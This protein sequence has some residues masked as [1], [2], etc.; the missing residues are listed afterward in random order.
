MTNNWTQLSKNKK[1]RE[2]ITKFAI[3]YQR[4]VALFSPS[5]VIWSIYLLFMINFGAKTLKTKKPFDVWFEKFCPGA[6]LDEING[7]TLM[8][9][10]NISL[11]PS[12]YEVNHKGF[13]FNP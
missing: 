7:N 9:S 11:F 1:I 5:I 3:K 13:P 12:H 2:R 4:E 6:I 8:D 10:N